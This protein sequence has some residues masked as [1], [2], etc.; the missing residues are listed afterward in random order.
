MGGCNGGVSIVVGAHG[1]VLLREQRRVLWAAAFLK[2]AQHD[3][4]T[5]FNISQLYPLPPLLLNLFSE[6]SF[7]FSNIAM[8]MRELL[9]P[10]N[11]LCA[12]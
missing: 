4:Q 7:G 10:N 11:S 6:G 5:S 8:L 2:S 12:Q 1:T 3:T 9:A